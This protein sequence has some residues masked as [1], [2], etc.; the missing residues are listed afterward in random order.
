MAN[1]KN[2]ILDISNNPKEQDVI[3]YHGAALQTLEYIIEKGAFPVSEGFREIIKTGDFFFYAIKNQFPN[4]IFSEFHYDKETAFKESRTYAE[5]TGKTLAF[6]SALDFDCSSK[7][8]RYNAGILIDEIE[9][10]NKYPEKIMSPEYRKI[11]LNVFKSDI[12]GISYAFKESQKR[13]GIVF[14]L[15]NKLLDYKP[16]LRGDDFNDL[17][18]NS[19][20]GIPYNSISSI[21][22]LGD[23][24]LEFLKKSE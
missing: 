17:K 20:E 15:N 3:A 18:V 19:L 4:E 16:I 10:I 24:E 9:E 21:H 6:L 13:E 8:M 2:Y 1:I 23:I 5:L 22:P 12:I 11:F 7:K 14:G